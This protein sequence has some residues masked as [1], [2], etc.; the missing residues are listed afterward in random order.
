[1]CARG[2]LCIAFTYWVWSAWCLGGLGAGGWRGG[3]VRMKHVVSLVLRF[4]G[5]TDVRVGWQ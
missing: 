3:V 2:G 5:P 1:M 4:A